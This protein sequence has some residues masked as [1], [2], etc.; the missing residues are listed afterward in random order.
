ME[1]VVL[2]NENDEVIG[3]CEKLKAHQ[4][5]LLHRAFSVLLFNHQGEMLI[6]QRAFEKYH[7]GGLWT[8]AC[9]SHQRPNESTL[10]AVKRRMPEELGVTAPVEHIG[11]FRYKVAFDNGL[12]EHEYDHVLFGRFNADIHPNPNE[13]AA[14]RYIAIRDLEKEVEES[15]ENFT[16]WFKQILK[17]YQ[18]HI[19]NYSQS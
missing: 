18:T 16:F 13:V 6:H 1:E 9:C 5:G 17:T 8:N 10:D 15:P 12:T 14:W 11:S 19:L 4:D 2:V 7:C 3:T